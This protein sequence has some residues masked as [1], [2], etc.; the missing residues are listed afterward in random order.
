M[1]DRVFNLK[2]SKV[3]IIL[4]TSFVLGSLVVILA[5]PLG[6][7]L[8]LLLFIGAMVYGAQLV[9]RN[10][11]LRGKSAIIAI[12]ALPD[13]K[14]V[15]TTR[16]NRYE[17]TLRADSTVT[18]LVSILRFQC[19]GRYFPLSCTVFRDSLEPDEYRQLTVSMRHR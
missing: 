13:N 14:W 1:L 2:P 6:V 8:K 7:S 10:G 17:T 4:L 11:F 19:P 18:H 9:W 3:Y 12:N 5:Q 16:A 15:L